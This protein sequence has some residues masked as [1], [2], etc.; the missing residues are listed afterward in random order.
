MEIDFDG[1]RYR[2]FLIIMSFFP[3]NLISY[4]LNFFWRVINVIGEFLVISH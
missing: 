2:E 4:E 3:N 1:E